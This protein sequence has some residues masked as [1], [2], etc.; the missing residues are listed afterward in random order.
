M[1]LDLSQR[2]IISRVVFLPSL[3]YCSSNW[4]ILKNQ[5]KA[6]RHEQSVRKRQYLRQLH[7]W[8]YY[9][10]LL[11]TYGSTD[12]AGKRHVWWMLQ[13]GIPEAHP[14]YVLYLLLGRIQFLT[15][16]QNHCNVGDL[17]WLLWLILKWSPKQMPFAVHQSLCIYR[18]VLNYL[19]S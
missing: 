17:F 5:H 18:I 3:P 13:S 12:K 1:Q 15:P 2:N 6:R 16:F 11:T 19:H 7:E 4:R 9:I 8:Q 14:S 10:W